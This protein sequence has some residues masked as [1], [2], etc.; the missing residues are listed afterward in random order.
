MVA[1]RSAGGGYVPQLPLVTYIV[2]RAPPGIADSAKLI[3]GGES[4]VPGRLVG[5]LGRGIDAASGD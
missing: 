4:L 1:G 2:G 3:A 5:R